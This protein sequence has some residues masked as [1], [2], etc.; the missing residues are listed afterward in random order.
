MAT[1]PKTGLTYE[2]LQAFPED[3]LR[4]EL[5]DGELIVTAAPVRRQQQA[6]AH[7]MLELGLSAREHGGE[8]LLAPFDVVFS[9]AN[10][11]EPD[12]LNAGG[13]AKPLLFG[14]GDVLESP[15]VPGP[16]LSIDEVLGLPEED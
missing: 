12:V 10:V 8:E 9:Q 14:R 16:M 13:Y 11:V 1:Q 5:I 2:D 15:V 4:R 7:L 3:N 6:V